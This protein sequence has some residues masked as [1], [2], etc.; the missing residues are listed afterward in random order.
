MRAGRTALRMRLGLL[1]AAFLCVAAFAWLSPAGFVRL[2]ALLGDLGWRLAAHTQRQALEQRLVIVDI[3]EASLAE[4]GPWP[5]PRERLAALAERLGEAGAALQVWDIVLDA[6]SPDNA[7]LAERLERRRALLAA[8][9]ALPGQ[10]E[11]VAGGKLGPKPGAHTMPC[12]PPWPM[13]HGQRAPDAAFASLP[14]GHVTPRASHDGIVRSLPAYVCREGRAWPALPLLAY[15]TLAQAGQIE[16]KSA[17]TPFDPPWRLDA[18]GLPAALPLNADGALVIPYRLPEAALQSV[19][20][21]DVLAERAPRELIEG[22][23]VLV[24]ST[25]FGLGD[26]IATPLA[27]PA[28]GVLVHAE[29]LA[30][31]LDGRLPASPRSAPILAWLVALLAMAALQGLARWRPEAPMLP[32]GGLIIAMALI[33]LRLVAQ[34]EF[35]LLLPVAAPA[36]AALLASLALFAYEYLDLARE[37]ARL[38]AHLSSYLPG[39]LA[40]R[41]RALPLQGR[42]LAEQTDAIVLYA[43]IRNFSAWSEAHAPQEVAE[44]LHTLFATAVEVIEGRGGRVEALEGDAILALWPNAAQDPAAARQALQ[45]ARWLLQ[46]VQAQLP[47]PQAIDALPAPLALGLGLEAGPVL[48]GSLGPRQRRQHLA[49]G[50]PVARAVR[51]A[52]MTAELGWPILIGPDLAQRLSPS[53]LPGRLISQGVFLLEGLVNPCEAFGLDI[54]AASQADVA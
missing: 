26:A 6:P 7:A 46:R 30:G 14:V 2:D 53:V 4:L 12:A 54:H 39:A 43:D 3:D 24:G 44:V 52:A 49:L 11:A 10:G 15:L 23:I 31:L 41:L 50:L 45:A 25:A 9:F 17:A 48:T 27:S 28:G 19:S 37:G 16:L 35:D 1:G 38:F 34:I 13:A 29:L 40:E 22:R 47:E 18:Q 8:A 42:V 51:L 20:A 21:R 5:W 32:W 33:G 36:I